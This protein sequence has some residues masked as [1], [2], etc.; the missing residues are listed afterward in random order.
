MALPTT[1]VRALDTGVVPVPALVPQRGMVTLLAEL[2][3][4]ARTKLGRAEVEPSMV[5]IGTHLA[6]GASNGG[7]SFHDRGGPYGATKGAKRAVAVDV[8]GLPLAAA[9]LPVSTHENVTTETL[10]DVLRDHGQAERLELVLVD[11]G[12]NARAAKLLSK[13]AA[14]EI[15]RAGH[16]QGTTRV[17]APGVRL[18]GRG[19]PWAPIAQPPA[20]PLLRVHA[21]VG[22]WLAPGRLPG[23]GAR[24]LRS[25]SPFPGGRAQGTVVGAPPAGGPGN[26]SLGVLA[27]ARTARAS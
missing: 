8:T 12:V 10:L 20:G 26:R 22:Q 25:P 1:A 21:R 2:H 27:S 4:K 15:R 23:G 14:L 7:A 6:R 5:V 24:R 11:R 9:V 13:R 17:R 19:R 16:E 3:R 18:A